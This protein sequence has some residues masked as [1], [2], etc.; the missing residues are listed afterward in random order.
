MNL[1]LVELRGCKSYC[2]SSLSPAYV[3]A[4]DTDSAYALVKKWADT[5]DYGFLDERGLKSV[6]LLAT[7]IDLDKQ[8]ISS[9]AS[10]FIEK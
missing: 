8:V 2:G 3:V 9:P 5:R 4:K 1:Y 7:Y 10:L 6:T